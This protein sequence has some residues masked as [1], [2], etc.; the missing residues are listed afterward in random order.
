MSDAPQD[1]AA[2]PFDDAAF[3]TL[4]EFSRDALIAHRAGK[5]LWANDAA[6]K[7]TGLPSG[8][9]MVGR[10]LLSFVA[11]EKIELVKARLQTMLDGQSVPIT[12]YD[13]IT[14]AGE[15]V[16]VEVTSSPMGDGVLLAAGRDLRP[17]LKAEQE[18]RTAEARARAFFDATTEAMGISRQGLHVEVNAA[19]AKLFGY[20]A[21]SDL[22]GLP[23]FDLLDESEHPR[24]AELVR[25]R[26]RGDP[27]PSTYPVMGKRR[28]G[29]T[30]QLEVQASGYPD[31]EITTTVVVMRDV[32][33][34]RAFEAKLAASEQR[35]RELFQQVPV[36]VWELDLSGTR[37]IVDGLR[38]AGMVDSEQHFA[39]HPADVLRCLAAIRVLS[40]NQVACALAGAK[41]PAELL[42]NLKRFILPESIP[43]LT[44]ALAQF[45]EGRRVVTT[46]GWA[47]TLGGARRWVSLRATPV[48]GHEDDWARVL[49]TTA[50]MTERWTAREEKEL[51][52][53]QLR[54]AE[55]L[56]AIGRLAGGVAHDFNNL[57][58]AILS[59]AEVSLDEAPPASPLHESLSLIREAS[60]RARDLVQQILTFG[61]KDKPRHMPLDLS[62]T[63]TQALGLARAA[64]ASTI[65][66]EVAV[67]PHVGTV[68]ADRTQVHQVVL[69]LVSNARDAVKPTGRITIGLQRVHSAEGHPEARLRVKDDGVGMDEALR[70]RLFEPY[71][72]TKAHGHGLGLAVV[73]G[74]VATTGGRIQVE[75]AVG[76]G[77]CIDVFFPLTES[78][79]P[80]LAPSEGTGRTN[81]RVLLVDDQ[82]LVR[83]GLKRLLV[84][85]GHRVTEAGDGQE[86]LEC[87]RATPG[88]FE[89]IISDQTMPRLSGLELARSLRTEGLTTPIILCSGFSEALNEANALAMGVSGVLAKPVDRDSMA[90]AVRRAVG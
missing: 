8:A 21:P 51:L 2:R 64:I 62:E 37:R 41:D 89:L 90:A 63:V 43:E 42:A 56:E 84:A 82:P 68:M 60:L 65:Q 1:E 66:L 45:V 39:A 52:Q 83:A 47:S 71:L 16:P 79:S 58:A 76:Q 81:L 50:D 86:A 31:G 12:Q 73:H 36:G 72:T 69:N 14:I 44:L 4:A 18:R 7:L 59:S 19:Y 54:H 34:Q 78:P 74:I 88:D 87:V 29:S 35:H 3:R 30:F 80:Q 48:G 11:P 13:L 10:A 70:A 15:R 26:A 85:M 46:E 57:L 28:D 32:T 61:R 17:R 55:K 77:T 49:V 33:A 67:A 75:S 23:I 24:V 20:A 27:T 9:A 38:A 40:V 22:V 53:E 6:A 5:I 25:R